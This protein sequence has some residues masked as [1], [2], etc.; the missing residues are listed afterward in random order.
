[1]ICTLLLAFASP[2]PAQAEPPPDGYR[3]D[4][5]ELALY[6]PTRLD[7]GELYEVARQMF[8]RTLGMQDRAIE[9]LNLLY[10]SI[11]IYDLPAEV[12]RIRA[13]LAGLEKTNPAADGGT[14]GGALPLL[15]D[16][17]LVDFHLRSLHPDTAVQALEPLLRDVPA[18]DESGEH[19]WFPNLQVMDDGLLLLRDN[20][21]NLTAMR[22]LLELLDQPPPQIAVSA[23]VLRGGEVETPAKLPGELTQNLGALLPGMAFEVLSRG[24]LQSSAAT[25]HSMQL[26]MLG[27]FGGSYNLQLRTGAFD[28]ENGRLALAGCQFVA[29]EGGG[30]QLLFDTSTVLRRGEYAVIGLTGADPVLLVLRFD[31]LP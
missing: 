24:L 1:M 13:A 3:H 25:G 16:I 20:A 31:P 14:G 18:R 17:P 15:R 10:D 4:Q 9:N 21:A 26:R 2:A 7:A 27:A 19:Q 28:A 29:D 11:V 23:W 30:A 12:A 22:S 8:G 5:L 6:T